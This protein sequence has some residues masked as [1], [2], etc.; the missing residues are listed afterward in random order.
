MK[1]NYELDFLKFVFTIVIIVYHSHNLISP[2][3]NLELL[4]RGYLG[5]EFFFMVS[6][7]L[8][9]SGVMRDSQK[10]VE[11]STW[12][13]V[14]KKIEAFLPATLFAFLVNFFVWAVGCKQYSFKNLLIEFLFT[15]P[16][17]MYI[18]HTGVAFP[19]HNYN[20][21]AWYIS[22]ML[23]GMFILYPFAKKFKERFSSYIAPVVG[24]A[25]YAWVSHYHKGGT[26]SM[27]KQWLNGINGGLARALAGL[28]LGA[29]VYFVTE[30]IK[31]SPRQLN[32]N[33]N[34]TMGVVEGVVIFAIYLFMRSD[35]TKRYGVANDAVAILYI[36]ALLLIVISKNYDLN[37]FFASKPMLFLYKLSLPLF[38]NQWAVVRYARAVFYKIDF[39]P[40]FFIYVAITV[41][42][43]LISLPCTKGMQ[44]LWE[45]ISNKL[46]TVKE[47]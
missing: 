31:N 34:I 32:K 9:M 13:F 19:T 30:N 27:I 8:M 43:A 3:A 38:L 18:R 22:A 45:I 21:P 42:L 23:V 47:A 37:K 2:D 12:S 39:L 35:A 5:V 6:G 24:V 1:R 14:G 28:C 46:T 33:G 16:E 11:R 20:G 10:G 29:F 44:K 25:M 40:Q 36:F 7:Y 26:F 15:P 41:V 17:I 4:S